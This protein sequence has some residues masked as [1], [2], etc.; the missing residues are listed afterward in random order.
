[1][2]PSMD[3]I[4]KKGCSHA[5]PRSMLIT[6]SPGKNKRGKKLIQTTIFRVWN[7]LLMV[8]INF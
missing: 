2:A 4:E 8:T 7:I 6:G 5:G 1:M 3:T